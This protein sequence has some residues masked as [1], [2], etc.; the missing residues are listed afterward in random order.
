M[1]MIDSSGDGEVQLD[2][3]TDFVKAELELMDLESTLATTKDPLAKRAMIEAAHRGARFGK[4]GSVE[5]RVK[6]QGDISMMAPA[7]VKLRGTLKK[8]QQIEAKIKKWW[9]DLRKLNAQ[10]K[11]QPAE[12]ILEHGAYTTEGGISKG[13]FFVMMRSIQETLN[14]PAEDISEA[15]LHDD[16]EKDKTEHQ[17]SGHQV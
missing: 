8:H 6:L 15:E 14:V 9:D 1:K 5:H 17:V 2:E 3:F 11:V 7:A 10:T 4:R 12:G 13:Q 16:W